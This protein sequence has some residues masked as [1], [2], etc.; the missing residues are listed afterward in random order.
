MSVPSCSMYLPLSLVVSPRVRVIISA[1]ASW[2]DLV[3]MRTP[4]V[5]FLTLCPMLVLVNPGCK[6]TI[7]KPSFLRSFAKIT[8]SACQKAYEHSADS[9]LKLLGQGLQDPAVGARGTGTCCLHQ[10]A[11]HA[12]NNLMLNSTCH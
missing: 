12:N 10:Q 6:L 4:S 3:G 1:T 5:D 7:V 11:L 9:L 2:G 8:V